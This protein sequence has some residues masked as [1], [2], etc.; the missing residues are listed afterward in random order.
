MPC[1]PIKP[2]PYSVFL[3]KHQIEKSLS[4]LHVCQCIYILYVWLFY[5][6]PVESSRQSAEDMDI[7]PGSTPTEESVARNLVM[8]S[9]STPS[10]L[11]QQLSSSTVSPAAGSGPAVLA[12]LPNLISQLG[13]KTLQRI[14]SQQLTH[15]GWYT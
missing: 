9:S 3:W 15:Q 2:Y 8:P 6:D 5:I 12:A 13:D 1:T 7:S 11:A 14:N 10:S 4:L